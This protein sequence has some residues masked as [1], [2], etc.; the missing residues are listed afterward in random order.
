MAKLINGNG[1]P[2]IYASQDADLIASLS[3]NTTSI[4][5]VGNEFEATQEDANTIGLADGVIIT[6]EGR[7]IQLDDGDTDLFTIPTGTAGTTSYYI[8]GYKL[9]TQVDSSQ[10]CETFVQKMN[11]S[12]ET[13]T[14][15]TFKG[16]ATD[17]YVS[18]YRVTQDGLNIDSINLLLPKLG[19]ISEL[20]ADLSDISIGSQIGNGTSNFTVSSSKRRLLCITK[21]NG[22][23]IESK[24]I[25]MSALNANDVIPLGNTAPIIGIDSTPWLSSPIENDLVGKE[26]GFYRGDGGSNYF[27]YSETTP[28]SPNHSIGL[29]ADLSNA[30]GATITYN[31]SNSF[32]ITVTDSTLSVYVY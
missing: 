3:G 26:L 30:L 10:T 2:A 4:A 27:M 21:N 1:N 5:A 11:S 7:R 17:V 8:I 9:S 19:N 16:G 14:E 12:S 20:N 22:V 29:A 15:D 24:E 23:I 31:G 6:Q 25:P 32:T 13:I 18:C 28:Q